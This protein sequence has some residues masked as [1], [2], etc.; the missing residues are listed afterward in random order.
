MKSGVVKS[1]ASM[2]IANLFILT[3]SLVSYLSYSRLLTPSKFAIFGTSL[4]FARIVVMLLD[5]GIRNVIIAD[6]RIVKSSRYTAISAIMFTIAVFSMGCGFIIL[7]TFFAKNTQ[8]NFI[9]LYVSPFLLSYPLFFSSMVRLEKRLNYDK[10]AI[11]E[12]LSSLIELIFPAILILFFKFDMQAFLIAAAI[13]RVVRTFCFWFWSHPAW[14]LFGWTDVRESVGSMRTSLW[15]QYAILSN[16]VRDNLPILLVAPVYGVRWAGFYIWALQICSVTSQFAVATASRISLPVIS[17]LA[18]GSARYDI[19]GQQIKWLAKLLGPILVAVWVVTPTLNTLAF[20]NRWTPAVALLPWLLLRMLPGVAT[21]VIYPLIYVQFGP[22][23]LALTST[24]WTALELVGAWIA[25][26]LLGP[27]GLAY[28]YAICVWGGVALLVAKI[29]GRRDFST[30]GLLHTVL[31]NSPTLVAIAI[32]VVVSLV[33][34]FIALA[35]ILH[36][37]V[38]VIAAGTL[39][40]IGYACDREVRAMLRTLILAKRHPPER[41][42]HL[43]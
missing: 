7:R 33:S 2:A 3:I 36:A 10:I 1:Y 41:L 29:D 15:F 17:S 43:K 31:F 39:V 32:G 35:P 25:L 24:L 16:G 22:R 8:V 30:V 23:W 9:F 11:I 12:A 38:V 5:G 42:Q 4:I 19:S 21:T 13:S 20:D 27:S 18:A 34:P 28:S 26:K 14:V 40:C 37:L 6:Q